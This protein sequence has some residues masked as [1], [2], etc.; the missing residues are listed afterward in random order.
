MRPLWRVTH[1]VLLPRLRRSIRAFYRGFPMDKVLSQVH[2]QNLVHYSSIITKQHLIW[3]RCSSSS[4]YTLAYQ[5]AYSM[6]SNPDEPPTREHRSRA[7]DRFYEPL[8]SY[9]SWNLYSGDYQGVIPTQLRLSLPLVSADI[10]PQPL[11][12][13]QSTGFPLMEGK[14]QR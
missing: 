1:A 9:Q 12:H 13:L 5:S 8:H 7:N 6:A 10:P 2:P 11:T 3:T 4:L 14:Y